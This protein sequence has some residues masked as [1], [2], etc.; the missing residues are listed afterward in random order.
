MQVAASTEATGLADV[1]GNKGTLLRLAPFRP[2]HLAIFPR[3]GF[4]QHTL[5][6]SAG[7]YLWL[8]FRV[9]VLFW[10]PGGVCIS[11]NVRDLNVG[12][13]NSHLV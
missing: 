13:V 9:C 1:V 8:L 11:M 2:V 4:I 7:L 5:I 6:Q 12:F 3:F 10:L